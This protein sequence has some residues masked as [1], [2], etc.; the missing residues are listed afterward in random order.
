LVHTGFG[1]KFGSEEY[2]RRYP[3]VT[4]ALAELL[5]EKQIR[6]LCLDTPSPD[7]APYRIH[8]ML[9]KN[10]ILIAENVASI[11]VLLTIGSFEVTALPLRIRADSSPGRI[12][13]R[14]ID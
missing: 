9:L 3:A 14:T 13:A 6:M 10:D 12:I 5:V 2:F 4:E 7:Y 11:N 8:G 1:K